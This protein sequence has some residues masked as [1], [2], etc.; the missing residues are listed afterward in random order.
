MSTTPP[1][2]ISSGSGAS[3]PARAAAR[4]PRLWVIAGIVAVAVL[5]Q[6]TVMPFVQV[7][8]GIPD[9][10]VCAIVA[11]GLLRGPLVGVIA[12][13][14]GGLLVELTSPAGTLGALALLYLA[15]GWGAGRLCGRDELT[16][17][18]P[19]VMLCVAGELVIQ[20]GE[21]FVQLMFA[22]PLDPGQVARTVLASVIMTALLSVPVV[23]IV[24]RLLGAPRVV[25]PFVL[26]GT[27]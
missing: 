15:V 8:N 2:V 20:T 10:L 4:G 14:A 7:A 17:V 11:I 24:R 6:V 27:Q 23:A 13:A 5:V 26:S 19:P 22:R 21:A 16:G 12:G 18:L 1:M 3:G 25:E 9:V